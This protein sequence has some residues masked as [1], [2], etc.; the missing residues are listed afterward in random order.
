MRAALPVVSSDVGGNRELVVP[1]VTGT[2][3]PEGDEKALADELTALLTD[4]I[5]RHQ[6]GMAGR[7]RYEQHFTFDAMLTRTEVVWGE[8]FSICRR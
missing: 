5:R 3:V 4:D 6:W 8:I 1:G 7:K 2:L